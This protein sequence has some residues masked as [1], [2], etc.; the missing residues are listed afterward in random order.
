MEITDE[1]FFEYVVA[2]GY[3]YT[4]EKYDVSKNLSRISLKDI[5]DTQDIPQNTIAIRAMI[6]KLG[7]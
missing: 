7:E 4:I 2:R 1:N 3:T 5:D 6:Y